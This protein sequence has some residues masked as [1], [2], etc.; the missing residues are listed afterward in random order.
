[1]RQINIMAIMHIIFE[2]YHSYTFRAKF[3]IVG[4]WVWKIR[5]LE[6]LAIYSSYGHFGHVF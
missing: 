2:E 6:V 3:Q 1:M 4:V 5:C